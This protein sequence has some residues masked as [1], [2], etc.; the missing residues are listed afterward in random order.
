MGVTVTLVQALGSVPLMWVLLLLLLLL[1]FIYDISSSS[2]TSGP[3]GPRPLPLI[4]N[5]LQ[6]D[7]RRPHESM[8]ELSKKFGSVF[9]VH[10][11]MKKVVVLCGY[12]T[13]KEA[14]LTLDEAFGEREAP[15]ILQEQTKG[16]GVL[17]SGGDSWKEMRRFALTNLRDFGMGKKAS[18]EK[19][20]E[21]C[22]HLSVVLQQFK[23][24][25][26]DMSNA[27]TFAVSNIICSIVYGSRFNYNDP[28]FRGQIG[29]ADALNHIQLS[30]ST[31]LY[32]LYPSLFKW[33]LNRRRILNISAE[34]KKQ[35][36]S[37]IHHLKESLNPETCRGFV[38]TFLVRQ[39][40]LEDSGNTD[41]HFHDDNLV[42]MVLDLFIA[43]TETTGTTLRWS[44]LLMARYPL[45][46]D[47]VQGELRSVLGGRQVQMED[48]KNLPYTNAVIHEVLRFSSIIPMA[49][50]H[51]TSRD[52]TFRGH[53]IKKGTTVYPLLVSVLHDESEWEKPRSFHPDHFLDTDGKFTK[54]DA[55]MP[56]SAGRR[57]CLG[58]TLARMELFLFFSSL[59]QRFRFTPPP[60]VPE[61]EL[62]LTPNV[63]FTLLPPTHKLCAVAL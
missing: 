22:Q 8:M 49:L 9:S 1:L 25:A 55:F 61:E 56:F 47:R 42:H 12:R 53:L 28:E 51:K 35:T 21:E 40:H 58:E 54:R 23:G 4:G 15:T 5:L 50:P 52:V 2:H 20:I 41:T 26:F 43:G 36:W 39:K 44:L 27:I 46:Q 34:N 32:N 19:I 24:E 11:G 7:L 62:D 57:I 38:D 18:E 3:P 6:I 45:I 48:R 30:V 13:V 33:L 29:R 31:Q 14:L 16:H 60:G 10:F 63:C 17:W 37:F 59:L